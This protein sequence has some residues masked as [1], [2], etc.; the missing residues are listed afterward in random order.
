MA[1][2]QGQQINNTFAGLLKTESN[3][4]IGTAAINLTDGLGNQTGLSLELGA[5]K[6]KFQQPNPH[7]LLGNSNFT[8]TN[9]PM[10]GTSG[11]VTY[12][13][14]LDGAGNY[15]GSIGQDRYGSLVYSNLN[16]D[17]GESHVFDSYTNT[18]ASTPAI[19]RMDTWNSQNNSN[20]WYTGYLNSLSGASYNSGTGDLT[21]NRTGAADVVVNIPTGGGGGGVEP[22]NFLDTTLTDG[23]NTSFYLGTWMPL[24]PIN[25]KDQFP[26]ANAWSVYNFGNS[27]PVF[28][29]PTWSFNAGQVIDELEFY[30]TNASVD[31][32]DFVVAIHDSAVD[33]S[34]A[35]T[36]G[37]M[38][39]QLVNSS[40]A[41]QSTGWKSFTG[42]NYTVA[43]TTSGKNLYWIGVWGNAS[44]TGSS[45]VQIKGAAGAPGLAHLTHHSGST[46]FISEIAYQSNSNYG[47]GAYP[48]TGNVDIKLGASN[49][50]SCPIFGFK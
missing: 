23:V 27:N 22:V 28:F 24:I 19:I 43:P 29:Y 49:A 34:G 46:T 25:T 2:L 21:L 35:M 20:N 50:L 5:Q 3:A 14:F 9:Y 45:N 1:S 31:F 17:Q 16:G 7:L 39:T 6:F 40:T 8:K 44:V 15:T 26:G 48:T 18:G 4:A 33:A 42:I 10:S 47:A 32:D 37:P 11:D 36:V 13:E 30:V 38:L 12:F 41:L